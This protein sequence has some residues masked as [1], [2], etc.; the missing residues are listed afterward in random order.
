MTGPLVVPKDNYP[1]GGDLNKVISYE[2]QREIFMSKKE[3]GWMEQP[4][5]MGGFAIENLPAPTANDH[6]ANK[7]YVDSKIPPAVDTSQLL[8]LD[9]TKDMTGN[10]GMGGNKIK[11]VGTPSTN[12]DATMFRMSKMR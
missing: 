11:N 4:I 6:A 9:G 3:G 8:K 1:V 7:G 10:L 12:S 2:A 5:D